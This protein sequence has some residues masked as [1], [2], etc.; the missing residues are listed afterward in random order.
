MLLHLIGNYAVAIGAYVNSD[1]GNCWW[2]LRSPGVAQYYSADVNYNGRI[3]D[4]GLDV[5]DDYYAI[6]PAMWITI[7]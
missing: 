5:D 4:Y 3:D 2:R 6:R 7:G 1:S